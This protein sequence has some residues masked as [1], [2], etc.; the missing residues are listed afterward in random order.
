MKKLS[1]LFAVIFAATTMFAET[2][3]W[4]PSEQEYPN[5]Q[6]I[7]TVT[8]GAN[9]AITLTFAKGTN[10]NAPKYYN[11]GTAVRLY[12]GNTLTVSVGSELM[13]EIVFTFSAGEGT[14]EITASAGNYESGT[15]TGSASE[16]TFTV[17][18]N[19]GHRRIASISVTYA[20]GGASGDTTSQDTTPVIV[21][22]TMETLTF[23]ANIWNVA[24]VNEKYAA[25][26]WGD[27]LEGMWTDFF[28][29]LNAENMYGAQIPETADSIV[30]VRLDNAIDTVTWSNIWNQTVDYA[31][32]HAD[33]YF[34]VEGWGEGEN[35]KSYGTW[36][37]PVVYNTCADVNAVSANTNMTLNEVT[38]VFIKGSNI[39]VK[40]ETG[41]T[42]V[43]TNAYSDLVPGDRV[44]GIAGQAKLY[45]GLPELAASTAFADLT[46]V[47]GDAPVIFDAQ[48]APTADNVNEVMMFRGVQMPTASFTTARA[49]N[50]NG[51]FAGEQVAFRNNWKEAFDFDSTKTYTMLGCVAIYNGNIQVYVTNIEEEVAPVQHYYIKNNWNGAE[52]W[53]WVEMNMIMNNVTYEYT[54]VF[55]GSGVNINTM[56][57]DDGSTWFPVADFRKI[58]STYVPQALDTIHFVYSI[59]DSA[60]AVELVGRPASDTIQHYYIKNNWNGG[61]WAWVEMNTVID[62]VL[63]DYTGVFGGSGVNINTM[64]SDAGSTWFP[65]A[66]FRTIDSTYVPQAMDTIH[67]VYSIVD[68]ALA[69]ELVGRPAPAPLTYYIKNNW[70]GGSDWAWVEMNTVIDNVLYDYTGVFGGSGVNINTMA[71]DDGSTWFPVADFGTIDST[72]VP[73]ALDTIHFVYSIVDSALAVELVGRPEPI[74]RDSVV[75]GIHIMNQTGWAQLNLY[76]WGDAGE[77]FGAWPGLVLDED[78][79]VE[80]V[81]G[82]FVSIIGEYEGMEG[83]LIFNDGNGVQ[84]RDLTITMVDTVYEIVVR[85]DGAYFADQV[86]AEAL[87]IAEATATEDGT[88]L[89]TRGIVTYINGKNAYIQDATAGILL[90]NAA[91]AFTNFSVGDEIIVNAKRAVYGNAPELSN[92]TLDT[93]LSFGNTV[94][95]ITMTLAERAAEPLK[96]F[97]MMIRVKSLTIVSFDRY[98]NPTVTDGVNNAVCYKMSVDTT[99]FH[100]G[101]VVDITAIASFFNGT[102]QFQGDIAGITMHEEDHYYIKNNWNGGSAW[103]W[104]EMSP[105]VDNVLYEYTGVFGGTGVN[106]NTTTA[107]EDATW[108]PVADFRTI[109]STYVPQAL[110]T[111]HFVYSIVDATLAV[112]LVGRP[113]GDSV[114]HYYIKNNWEA[115]SEWTWVEMDMVIDSSVY[116]YTGVFGGTGVNINTMAS[117][118]GAIWFPVEDFSL[119]DP[120]YVPQALDTIHFVYSIVDSAL[121]VE[122][123]GRPVIEEIQ[124]Y[125]KNNWNGGEWT[126]EEMTPANDGNITWTY[127]GIFGGTGVN[128][129]NLPIDAD[130]IWFPVD[131]WIFT[132]LG[133]V[134]E[135]GDDILF[136]FDS[137]LLTLTATFMGEDGLDTVTFQREGETTKLIHNGQLYI[138][139]D[140]KMYNALGAQVR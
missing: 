75:T 116:E 10:N 60:L 20:A 64:A 6:A 97:G 107:D 121:A 129:N 63:Y 115:G 17:G 88:E 113:A 35:A 21:P 117:D 104:E 76:M 111:I 13:S 33:M 56:A 86:P 133:Y 138:I 118:A 8:F 62:N 3:T 70:N 34:T 7:E 57:S 36:G 65:V 67:F 38:V 99:A 87:T 79:T 27:N 112:E 90:Y 9:D 5:A 51:T 41:T 1:L 4:V 52:A 72:Y 71:S 122:L 135:A 73:Q 106:I 139:R 47:P 50:I 55:G 84:F 78:V 74:I 49:T 130:A 82:N 134:P 45:N 124:Y 114:L 31:I 119:I 19:S 46:V 103:T 16:I 91:A 120:T 54:G 109:D 110:D 123:V 68:S 48:A 125:I 61:E 105:V 81:E 108:F 98:N 127:R 96:N 25:W 93:I 39:Y 85:A 58:D 136:E 18:G 101:D 22:V 92:V 44:S 59:V 131:E 80:G 42:L 137:E 69:V 66:D 95:P 29:P 132:T 28:T 24:D 15:W 43:Y 89:K 53:T 100:V 12:G 23:N 11:A 77:L 102:I 14:N 30:F 32:N 26:V 94:R 37:T 128:I 126:W 83:N 140:G 40:D 2:A